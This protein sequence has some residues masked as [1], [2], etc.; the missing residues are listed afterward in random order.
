MNFSD[1]VV[2]Y[3][4]HNHVIGQLINATYEAQVQLAVS[5]LSNNILRWK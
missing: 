5:Y 2:F 1:D 3:H 4:N